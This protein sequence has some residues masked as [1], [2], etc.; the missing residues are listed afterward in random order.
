MN[1]LHVSYNSFYYYIINFII[2][3]NRSR[4]LRL[5]FRAKNDT[6]RNENTKRKK[7]INF[8]S[9]IILR[10]KYVIIS[11]NVFRSIVIADNRDCNNAFTYVYERQVRLNDLKKK[12]NFWK[13]NCRRHCDLRS[14]FF[15]SYETKYMRVFRRVS[16]NEITRRFVNFNSF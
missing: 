3:S 8:N 5:H 6:I 12:W 1:F 2:M 15:A 4:S 16:L 10:V 11:L 13:Y 14:S 9:I 7:K